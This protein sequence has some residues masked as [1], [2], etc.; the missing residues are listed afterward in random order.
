MKSI[1]VFRAGHFLSSAL[2]PVAGCC[3]P[4]SCTQE[5]AGRRWLSKK[6]MLSKDPLVKL[7]GESHVLF[8]ERRASVRD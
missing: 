6:S 2:P 4:I 3:E 1:E 5:A 8:N 7:H